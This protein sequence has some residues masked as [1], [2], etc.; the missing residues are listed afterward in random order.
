MELLRNLVHNVVVIVLLSTFLDLILPSSNMQRYI[1]VVMGLFVLVT[2]LTPFLSLLSQETEFE[3]FNW[4]QY[5]M[6][7]AQDVIL[8]DG[9]RISAVNQQLFIENYGAR[10]EK[11]MESLVKLVQGVNKVEVQ[12]ELKG[13]VQ[14]GSVEGMER[15]L[16]MV[17]QGEEETKTGAWPKIKPVEIQGGENGEQKPSEKLTRKDAG[18]EEKKIE[19]AIKN[20]LNQYFGLKS[21]QVTVV[22]S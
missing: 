14:V 20:T 10:I 21:G 18:S 22:F 1:K 8:Q 13:G 19:E 16:V 12:V 3:V 4:Q 9:Q 17:H 6:G 7:E 2:L 5:S 15:V 11:Q